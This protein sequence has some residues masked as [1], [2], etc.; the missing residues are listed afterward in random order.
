LLPSGSSH[1]TSTIAIMAVLGSA[2]IP[3]MLCTIGS[4]SRHFRAR[5]PPRDF[6]SLDCGPA[7]L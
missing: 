4:V 3:L 2:R 6:P 7:S 5:R 1:D